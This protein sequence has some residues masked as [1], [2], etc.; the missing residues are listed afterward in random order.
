MPVAKLADAPRAPSDIPARIDALDW[1]QIT[2]DLDGQGC[3]V[4]KNLLTPDECGVIAALYPDESHFRSRVV[5][6]R[7]GFGRGEYQYFSYPLPPLIQQ[8]RPALY[9]TALQLGQ[10]LER[11]DGSRYPLSRL[12]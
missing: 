10:S 12:A 6:A 3:A 11:G 8:L 5:M 1:T 9:A 2:A 4:L 7:H